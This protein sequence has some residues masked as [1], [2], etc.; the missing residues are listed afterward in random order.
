ML[1]RFDERQG[2]G[3]FARAS[4]IARSS[5]TLSLTNKTIHAKHSFE[6][7]RDAAEIYVVL[8]SRK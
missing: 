6:V 4:C 2:F 7:L 3:A 5:I 8:P 1:D